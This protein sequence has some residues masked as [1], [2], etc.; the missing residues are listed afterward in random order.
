MT[1]VTTPDYDPA[2]ACDRCHWELGACT[3]LPEPPDPV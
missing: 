1:D 3:C 2:P